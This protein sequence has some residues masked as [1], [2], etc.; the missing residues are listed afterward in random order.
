MNRSANQKMNIRKEEIYR[1]AT[2]LFREKGYNATG[3]RDI[4]LE[5]G[6]EAASLY[7]HIRSKS[8]L[9]QQCCFRMTG[10]FSRQLEEQ[11]QRDSSLALEKIE[12][13]LRFHI[14]AWINRLDEVL[15][16]THE[17]KYL[18][19]PWLT[20]FM[21]E[22]R[23]YMKRIEH[24]I[25]QGMDHGHIRR[26]ETYP[27]M[28]TIMSTV[29]GIEFWHRKQQEVSAPDLEDGLV[30]VIIRGLLPIPSFHRS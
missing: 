30:D 24:I 23:R 26:A 6:V 21:Q 19:E 3:M 13:I 18:E 20:E 9:L 7:N 27:I 16:A 29:R 10:D 8:E 28:L 12:A 15:V 14:R 11:E 4:A 22:R 17:G 25:R 2:R 1:V 5:V